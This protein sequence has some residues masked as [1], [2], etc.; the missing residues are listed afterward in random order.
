MQPWA[1]CRAKCS[2][3][4]WAMVHSL[5]AFSFATVAASNTFSK[6]QNPSR[7]NCS[8]FSCSRTGIDVPPPEAADRMAAAKPP[9]APLL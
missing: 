6:M 7:I 9:S 3:S 5:M 4:S 2:G 1:R 8:R